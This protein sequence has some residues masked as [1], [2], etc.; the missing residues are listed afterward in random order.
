MAN[1]I[2]EFRM[3]KHLAKADEKGV[4]SNDEFNDFIMGCLISKGGYIIDCGNGAQCNAVAILRLY[5]KIKKHPILW[6][7]FMIG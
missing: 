2:D 5:Y 4:I 7:L 6:K 1:K 3:M